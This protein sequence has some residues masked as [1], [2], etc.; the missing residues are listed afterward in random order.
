LYLAVKADVFKINNLLMFIITPPNAQIS[1][2]KIIVNNFIIN[3]I[4]LICALVGVIINIKQNART[5][6]KIIQNLV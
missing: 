2:K 3:F 5:N 4:L 6:I 1:S